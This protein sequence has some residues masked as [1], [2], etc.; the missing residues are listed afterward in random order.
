MKHLP[1]LLLGYLSNMAATQFNHL[2][3]LAVSGSFEPFVINIAEQKVQ[4]METL[5]RLSPVAKPTY[6]NLKT[7]GSLGL[8]RDWLLQTKKHW[9][10]GFKW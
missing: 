2:P 9:L 3:K 6:E 1:I 4:D 8:N 5:I 10:E 7:D